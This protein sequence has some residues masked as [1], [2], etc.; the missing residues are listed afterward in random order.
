[1]VWKICTCVRP[2]EC[3]RVVVKWIYDKLMF[4]L[5]PEDGN[6]T[7]QTGQVTYNFHS[8]S[9]FDIHIGDWWENPAHILSA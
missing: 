8:S 6:S 5:F 4:G 2:A 3:E 7:C 1:M 9:S